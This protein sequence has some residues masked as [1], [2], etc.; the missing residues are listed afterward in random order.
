[1]TKGVTAALMDAF[2]LTVRNE[3]AYACSLAH[4][5]AYHAKFGSEL[6]TGG[7]GSYRGRERYRVCLCL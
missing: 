7:V 1:M 3:Y 4:A 5:M 6:V 2:L